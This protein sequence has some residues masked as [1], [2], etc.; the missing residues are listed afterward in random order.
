METIIARVKK[1]LSNPAAEWQLINSESSNSITIMKNYL[2]YLIGLAV[3]AHYIGGILSGENLFGGLILALVQYLLIVVGF[4]ISAFIINLLAPSFG[5]VQ[6]DQKA[7][8]LVA[9]SGTAALVAQI[10]AVLPFLNLLTIIGSLYTFFLFYV[11]APICSWFCPS[12]KT[13]L[14]TLVCVLVMIGVSLAGVS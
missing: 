7:F 14:F 6:D 12:E 11:G 8:K 2:A 3:A 10:F 5:A 9:Y 13:L 4:Y 1:L